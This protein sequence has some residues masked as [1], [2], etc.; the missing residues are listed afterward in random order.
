MCTILSPCMCEQFSPLHINIGGPFCP[1]PSFLSFKVASLLLSYY[2]GFSFCFGV[3]HWQVRLEAS[4]PKKI[5]YIDC[6][7]LYTPLL[8]LSP[9]YL[10]SPWKKK[11]NNNNKLSML[12]LFIS[13]TRFTW[14]WLQIKLFV[15]RP[16]IGTRLIYSYQ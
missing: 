9:T 3:P 5:S 13:S 10:T 16:L 12:I 1:T 8:F 11:N 7:P 4:L 2:L 14:I 15:A 6:P